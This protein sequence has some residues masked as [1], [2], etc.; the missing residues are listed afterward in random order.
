VVIGTPI[1]VTDKTVT[2]VK[3]EYVDW[4]SANYPGEL[5]INQAK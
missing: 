1:S 5:R 3:Q 2:Q 4:I